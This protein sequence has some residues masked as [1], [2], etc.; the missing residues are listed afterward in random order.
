VLELLTPAEMA[1]ADAAAIA[2]GVPGIDLMEAAGRAVAGAALDMS[3]GREVLVVA[4]GGNNGGDGF[5]AARHLAAVG[6]TVTVAL[7]GDP[8][9]LRGDAAR[10]FRRWRGPVVRATAGLPPARLVIDALF[11]AGLDRPVTGAPAEIVAAMNRLGAPVLA[12]DVPSGLDGATGRAEG[13]VVHARATVTFFRKKPGHLLHPGRGLCGE[14]R[15]APIGIPEDVLPAIGPRVFENAPA[16]WSD[17]FP[18]ASELQHKYT[19]GHAVVVSGGMTRTGAARLAAGA[20]LRAGSGLVTIASPP[21]AIAVNAAHLTA[22][23]LRRIDNAEALTALLEDRRFT[24]IAL[25]PGLG[26]AEAQQAL[27][28]AALAS[29]QATVLDADALTAFAG[30]PDRLCA[31]ISRAPAAVVLT[32]HEGEFARLFPAL[33]EGSK[34]ARAVA[35]A[36]QSGAVMILK[37]PDTVVAAPDGR[38][39]INANAP[40]WLASAGSGD[41]LTGIVTG[42]LAQGVPAWQAACAAV[43]L[44]GAAGAEAGPGLIAEDLDAAL[45]VVIRR[46]AIG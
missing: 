34:L 46:H 12:V 16:L 32:P 43:W 21:D 15:L 18:K 41:V 23:M 38:A 35:A 13:A 30:A 8:G 1:R 29:P 20:A 45:R 31:A 24:T 27:V 25:G 11:G 28:L 2:G 26:L 9:R 19:R 37:G 39:A 3:H 6:R 40:P 10:A 17:V 42:L 14:V 5:V 7:W 44:H 33:G 22:V 4:G 36:R